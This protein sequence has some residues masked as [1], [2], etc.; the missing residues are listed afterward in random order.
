MKCPNCHTGLMATDTRCPACGTPSRVGPSGI[1]SLEARAA[2]DPVARRER[3]K[4]KVVR[5][6]LTLL[7]GL[8]LGVGGAWKFLEARSLPASARTVTAD[9]LLSIDRPEAQ[10]EWIAY[11]PSKRIDTGVEYVK[12][13]SRKT[14]SKFVLLG[15]HDRWL[16]AKVGSHHDGGRV[17]GKLVGF[18]SAALPKVQS[19]LP[20]LGQRLLPYQLDADVELA[21]RQRGDYILAGGGAIFGVLLVLSAVG[22]LLGR[23]G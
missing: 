18:D 20:D 16:L 14:T 23:R 17:E 4:V 9:D 10:P 22:G 5:S 12:L 19:A 13:N 7:I 2:F 6:V 8:G 1:S 21:G 11:R 15:V 3:S